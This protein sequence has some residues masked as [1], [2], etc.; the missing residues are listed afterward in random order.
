MKRISVS[1]LLIGL[2]L[3]ANAAAGQDGC[4]GCTDHEEIRHPKCVENCGTSESG[5]NSSS[6]PSDSGSS[7]SAARGTQELKTTFDFSHL[8]PQ[9]AY[10][11]EY[12]NK[13]FPDKSALTWVKVP[14]SD[15][16]NAYIEGQALVDKVR[17]TKGVDDAFFLADW[18]EH[19]L[20]Y[21]AVFVYL[22][23]IDDELMRRTLNELNRKTLDK[24]ANMLRGQL[25]KLEPL[26][27]DSE[28][29]KAQKLET[30]RKREA[31]LRSVLERDQDITPQ[32][33]GL[34]K[35]LDWVATDPSGVNTHYYPI[36]TSDSL[37]Q[38]LRVSADGSWSRG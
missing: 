20:H 35:H 1:V 9:P 19:L 15:V 3:W 11:E 7:S 14:C 10:K 33:W 29:V 4:H 23:G 37:K 12:L 22:R 18:I 26:P 16:C 32:E 24:V 31:E 2:V 8:T 13:L 30:I 25:V 21:P 34:A 17:A 5:S 38:L 27:W 28:D 36:K 6:H